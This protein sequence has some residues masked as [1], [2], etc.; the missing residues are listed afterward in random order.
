MDALIYTAMS[1]AQRAQ[2][3]QHTVAHNLANTT[4]TGFRASMAVAQANALPGPGLASRHYAVQA[5]A[6]LD[7]TPGVLETTGRALDVAIDGDG[8]LA[9]AALPE[10]GA[11]AVYSR[12][13]SLMLDGD[14]TL[15]LHGRAVLGEGGP[16]VVP[17]HHELDIGADGTVSVR[18]EGAADLLPVGTLQRVLAMPGDMRSAGGGLFVS[19]AGTLPGDDVM[20]RGAHLEASNVSAVGAMV[21][22]MNASRDFEMQMRVL[23]I[24]DDMAEGGNRL[25]RG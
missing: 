21:Q 3:A 24:A 19:D 22:S 2:D 17:P 18:L 12:G 14:G 9:L 13:G 7:T 15:L 16:I 4:T 6:G 5:P 25:V 1:G 20:L 8:Y 23:K 10:D 11:D